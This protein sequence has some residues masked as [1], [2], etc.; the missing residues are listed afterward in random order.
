MNDKRERAGEGKESFSDE[1]QI[2][3]KREKDKGIK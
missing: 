3:V 2:P 1:G